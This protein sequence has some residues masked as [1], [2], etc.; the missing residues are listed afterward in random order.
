[1]KLTLPPPEEDEELP[2]EAIEP[3]VSTAGVN[4]GV[5]E[6]FAITPPVSTEVSGLKSCLM[7]CW[8]TDSSVIFISFQNM[9][10]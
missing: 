5:G 8:F 7:G 1:M 9:A 3:P 2:L 10:I 4:N 6:A